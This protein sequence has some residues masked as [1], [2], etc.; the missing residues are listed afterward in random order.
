[1]ARLKILAKNME[2]SQN[3]SLR[4]QY[5]K[6]R[7]SLSV[8]DRA[9]KSHQIVTRLKALLEHDFERADIFLCFYPYGSEVDLLEFYSY[10]LEKNK[11]IYFPVTN[12][13]DKS[14]TFRRVT[15]LTEDFHEGFKGIME[16]KDELPAFEYN[17]DTVVITPGLVFDSNINRI[18][19]GAGYYDRFF[20]LYPDLTK[21][22]VCFN[23]QICEEIIP[24]EHDFPMDY[25][26]TDNT[27]IR[28]LNLWH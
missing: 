11:E 18:G 24:E 15:N 21:V 9:Q 25:I 16:P 7:D 3:K 17:Q 14:L 5:K 19:Y 10:L 22:G 27:F 4:I 28:R 12:K 20:S 8:E 23:E 6:I 13:D 1:M 2:R 26:V